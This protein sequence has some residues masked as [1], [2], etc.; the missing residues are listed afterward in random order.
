M[1][2]KNI[3]YVLTCIS[4]CILI[5][6]GV[7]EHFAVWPIAFSAPPK[8]LTMFQGEYAMQPASFWK[9]IH[10]MTLILFI[11]TLVMN[12][13]TGRRKSIL[14]AFGIYFLMIIATFIYFVPQLMQIIGT[15]YTETVDTSLQKSGSLWITLSLVRAVLV[16]VAAFILISG[17]TIS[18]SNKLDS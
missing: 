1:K 5:G 3:F 14:T 18:D 16:L 6:A 9:L 13:R 15:P 11:I 7:Y 10:P 2:G 17:L 8:S 4:V 12:W